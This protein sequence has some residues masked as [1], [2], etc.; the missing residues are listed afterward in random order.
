MLAVDLHCHSNRSDGGLSPAALVARAAERGV[1]LLALT[2]HDEV[3]GLEAARQAAAA[4][5]VTL[6]PGVEISAN[7]GAVP[8][9][10]V[11]LGI[12]PGS[13]AL[14]AGI[15]RVR[16]GRVRR[17]EAIAERLTKLGMHGTLEGA[18]A[19]ASNPA[20]ISRTH[21]ARHLVDRGWV[22]DMNAAFRRFLGT[23]KPAYVRHRWAE[24]REAVGWIR[25]AG[26]AAVLAHPARYDLRTARL[27]A[28]LADFKALG[29]AAVEVITAGHDTVQA[30][31]MARIA[32]EFDL[33]V[34][35]GSDFHAP[36]E[37]WLDLGQLP[38]LPLPCEP[39]WRRW[40]DAAPRH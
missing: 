15:E 14:L 17:A 21:F 34:S 25:A 20:M 36:G 18:M 28:L 27:R 9:H 3:S 7:W 30:A 1:K 22:R 12:D 26:G 11:G 19:L 2:D 24:L 23:D 10:V 35:A 32:G 6:L 5:G 31:R 40:I 16:S 4:A 13:A 38:E 8:V 39:V 33:A 37:S 29:G